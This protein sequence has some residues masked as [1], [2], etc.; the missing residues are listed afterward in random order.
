MT[1]D[2]GLVEVQAT[3]ERTPLSRAHL[4]DLLA[5][6]AQRDRRRCATLQDEAVA[7]GGRAERMAAPDVAGARDPQPAQAA[8]VRAAAGAGRDRGRAAARRGRAAARG[9][10]HVR[11]QRAAQGARRGRGAPGARRSPTTRGSR[12]RRS[13]GAPACA[14]RA[15][16]A[17]TRPTRE[18][19]EKLLR[20]APAGSGLRYVCALAYVDPVSGHR[21]GVLRRLPRPARRA[22][23]AGE[24]RLRLRPGLPA[25]RRL[26][27]R[28]MAEL[29]D[30]EKDLISHRGRAVR[31]TAAL[32]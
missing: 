22:S 31:A 32:G 27:G 17:S 25:R 14:R 24:R 19:L 2:G 7:A 3:A 26:G 23:R 1:G 12:P 20:E 11:G 6:A 16:P 4:D 28:T 21:A 13:A 8:G 15:T 30:D 29:A 10:R 9:R 5:L 18:N